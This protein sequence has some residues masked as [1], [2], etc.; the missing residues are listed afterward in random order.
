MNSHEVINLNQVIEAARFIGA[1]SATIGI[2]GAGVGIVTYLDFVNMQQEMIQIRN[3]SDSCRISY[4]RYCWSRSR[5]SYVFGSFL[6]AYSR[7][8][9][10]GGQMFAYTLL[11]FALCEAI[12]LFG[13]MMGF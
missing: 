9:Q 6:V 4:N 1:G 5:N 13:L 8:P 10:M 12:A 3:Y 2:A 7:N 11:G